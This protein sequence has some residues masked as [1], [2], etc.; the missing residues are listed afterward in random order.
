MRLAAGLLGVVSVTGLQLLALGGVARAADNFVYEA[1]ETVRGEVET[2]YRVD[3]SLTS[4]PDGR[5]DDA[6]WESFITL[7]AQHGCPF[8][9]LEE[10]YRKRETGGEG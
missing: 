8:D 4:T 7:A 3:F 1:S 2:A 5:L 6:P 10:W 9:A